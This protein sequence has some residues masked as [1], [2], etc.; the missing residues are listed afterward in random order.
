MGAPH[1]W[2]ISDEGLRLDLHPPGFVAYYRVAMATAVIVGA[3]VM[4]LGIVG[5]FGAVA[6]QDFGVPLRLVMGVIGSLAIGATV[7]VPSR[8]LVAAWAGR[9]RI[10]AARTGVLVEQ[11]TS[12]PQRSVW[13][14]PCS[15]VT[16]VRPTIDSL[17]RGGLVLSDGSVSVRIGVGLRPR[18]VDSLRAAVEAVVAAGGHALESTSRP[19]PSE[20]LGPSWQTSLRGLG[21]EIVR[22]LRHPTPYLM[23]DV[24]AIV[25]APLATTALLAFD[26]RDVYPL[27]L[28]IFCV[29]LALRRFDGSYVQG[30]RH[31]AD[32]E[33]TWS[34]AYVGGGIAI[35]LFSALGL[36]PRLGLGVACGLA[37]VLVVGLHVALLRRAK[38]PAPARLSRATDFALGAT[39]IPISL[40]HEGAMFTFVADSSQGLG[41]L[42]LAMVPMTALL[43]YVPVRMHAF[44]DA[45]DDRGN[46]G[47][48][49]ITVGWLSLQPLLAL[50]PAIAAEM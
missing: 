11:G 41:P 48:F 15:E 3:L 18:D 43:T 8:L 26:W 19:G 4:P 14:S 49:W 29:G 25:A 40:L 12:V 24:L 33:P 21:H 36:T 23:V 35:A 50:G 22:P 1:A 46:R 20:A 45:P 30:M 32:T 7:W 10:V 37:A 42:A 2:S 39:L 44:V 47:W 31:Y 13:L 38:H 5:L 34:L 6:W 27:A 17:E 9:S 28:V 16:V